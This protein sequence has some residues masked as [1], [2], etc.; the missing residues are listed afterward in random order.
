MNALTHLPQAL[1]CTGRYYV[2]KKQRDPTVGRVDPAAFERLLTQYDAD[3][4]FVHVGLSAVNAA[5]DDDPYKYLIDVL[6][7]QFESVLV[8]GFTPSFRDTGIYDKVNS[9]PEIGTFS[10]LFMAD[11]DYRT[12]DPIH[13]IQVSG[14]YRFDDCN[15]HD[16]FGSDGCYARLEVDDVLI[17]NVGTPWL[18]STQLHYVEMQS[19][20]PYADPV[21]ASGVCFDEAG[22]CR[23][24]VQRTFEKNEYVYYWNRDKIRDDANAAGI[25]DTYDL[26][27]L[28]VIAVGA[29]DLSEF[30]AP[31][32][33]ADP[34]YLVT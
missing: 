5:F 21:T 26:N 19:D 30:L 16:T 3:A 27:G 4:V 29:R 13:S 6:E 12:D 1:I 9:V 10:R 17:L 20:P 22:D 25:L 11:A 34:Y 18:I 2:K 24:V 15:H 8:P 32:L 7:S 28:P 33:A 14:P 23:P 31:K